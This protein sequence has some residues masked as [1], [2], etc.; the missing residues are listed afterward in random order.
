MPRPRR[1]LRLMVAPL[2]LGL[3]LVTGSAGCSSPS[4]DCAARFS[5]FVTEAGSVTSGCGALTANPDGGAGA[6]ALTLEAMSAH[7]VNLQVSVTLGATPTTGTFSS[8]SIMSWSAI[9]LAGDGCGYG[10]GTEAVPTGSFTMN[11]TKVDEAGP[12]VHGTLDMTLYVHAPPMT[13][14]GPDETEDVRFTF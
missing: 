14:C 4:S 3:G 11:I 6:Y 9:G 13:D 1:S 2:A 5:G 7:V 12:V 8:D 10:A